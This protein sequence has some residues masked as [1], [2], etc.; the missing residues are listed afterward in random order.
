MLYMYEDVHC[1]KVQMRG[2]QQSHLSDTMVE[3][4]CTEIHE[5]DCE[6]D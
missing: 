2:D 1:S 4:A 3:A 5:I 6:T